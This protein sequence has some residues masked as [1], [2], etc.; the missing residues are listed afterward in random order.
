MDPAS[1]E[2]SL[3]D[4]KICADAGTEIPEEPMVPE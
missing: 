4:A 3:E 2:L 1:E